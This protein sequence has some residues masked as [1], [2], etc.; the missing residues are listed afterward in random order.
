MLLRKEMASRDQLPMKGQQSNVI[1]GK[2]RQQ[3]TDV[4]KELYLGQETWEWV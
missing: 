1:K 4:T 2:D 3:I